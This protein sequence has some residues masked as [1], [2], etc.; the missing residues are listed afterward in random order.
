MALEIGS[1]IPGPGQVALAGLTDFF[2]FFGLTLTGFR[3]VTGVMRTGLCAVTARPAPG[4]GDLKYTRQ[5][6]LSWAFLAIMQAVTRL[7][8]GMASPQSRNA[9]PLHACCCSGV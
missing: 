8:S 5:P 2:G 3:A 6:G 4:S 9:S 1:S 7:T